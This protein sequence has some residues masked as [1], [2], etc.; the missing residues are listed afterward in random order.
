MEARSAARRAVVAFVIAGCAGE[1]D[2][3][4][5]PGESQSTYPGGR[6]FGTAADDIWFAESGAYVHWDGQA[7][8]HIADLD[9]RSRGPAWW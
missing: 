6:Y 9:C 3:V 7:W 4:P 5:F 2:V 1:A 8:S